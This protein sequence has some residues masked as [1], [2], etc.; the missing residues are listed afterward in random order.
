MFDR[1]TFEA[2]CSA[3]CAEYEKSAPTVAEWADWLY[4]ANDQDVTI[5]DLHI[6]RRIVG[7]SP[8]AN[9]AANMIYHHQ[10]RLGRDTAGQAGF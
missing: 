4:Q 10:A 3:A 2:A 5:A 9:L 1:K 7:E 6:L 8:G